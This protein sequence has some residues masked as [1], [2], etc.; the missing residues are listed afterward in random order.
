MIMNLE[1]VI[2]QLQD[3]NVS[4]AIKSHR[5]RRQNPG[6]K[7]EMRSSDVLFELLGL[8]PGTVEPADV[9]NPAATRLDFYVGR[10]DLL[11]QRGILP[12]P[13]AAASGTGFPYTN[14]SGKVRVG[15]KT[16]NYQG[17]LVKLPLTSA[18]MVFPSNQRL[19][20]NHQPSFLNIDWEPAM[21][22][23]PDHT[24]MQLH[25]GVE[26][27]WGLFTDRRRTIPL[28]RVVLSDQ[29]YA[30]VFIALMS[31]I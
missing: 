28:A 15:G 6:L 12:A 24:R 9:H 11:N 2:C 8:S 13:R 23:L 3:G 25:F 30:D 18:S 10:T 17:S 29:Q 14:P 16:I 20:R 22:P 27:E 19:A 7:I 5:N 1:Y 31:I 4:V 26:S 21:Y